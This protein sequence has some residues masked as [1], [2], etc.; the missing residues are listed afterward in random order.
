MESFNISFGSVLAEM[1]KKRSLYEFIEIFQH[2]HQQQQQ[3]P[4]TNNKDLRQPSFQHI[5]H[6]LWPMEIHDKGILTACPQ[7]FKDLIYPKYIPRHPI[8]LNH[9]WDK[10]LHPRMF[11]APALSR[12]YP[13]HRHGQPEHSMLLMLQGRKHFVHWPNDAAE[14]LYEIKLGTQTETG[15]RVFMANPFTNDSSQQPDMV[16]AQGGYEGVVHVIMYKNKEREQTKR[17]RRYNK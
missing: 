3:N 11:V 8:S 15:D 2:H 6:Y 16:K 9:I 7:L 12:A 4:T 17:R 1:G 5:S 14:H 13:T 10:F